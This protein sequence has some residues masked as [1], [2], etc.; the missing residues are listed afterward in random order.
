MSKTRIHRD[1][2]SVSNAKFVAKKAVSMEEMYGFV[3]SKKKYTDRQL[4]KVINKQ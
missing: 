3:R 2:F 4:E 1:S